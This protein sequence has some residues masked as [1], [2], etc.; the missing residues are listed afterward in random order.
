MIRPGQSRLQHS[1]IHG[2]VDAAQFHPCPPHEEA[3]ARLHYVAEQH[4]RLGVLL[5]NSGSGKSMLLAKLV[6]DLA[7]AGRHIVSVS[8]L[9]RDSQELLFEIAEKL[10]C[11]PAA[12]ANTMTLWRAITDRLKTHKYQQ[13]DT[14]FLFDDAHEASAETLSTICRLA[15]TDATEEARLTI[16]MAAQSDSTARLPRRLLD[17][18]ALRIDVEPWEQEDTLEFLAHV[19]EQLRRLDGATSDDELLPSEVFTG[20]AVQTLHQLSGGLPRR[21]TQLAQWALLAGAGLGL[22]QVNDE[23]VTSAAEELGVQS[24]V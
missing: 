18:T 9:G 13:E 14:V 10:G 21:V 19:V 23:V 16:I 22:E 20:K 15:D 24:L 6:S 2:H 11:N 5:G 4:L 8:L 12:T 17:R 1:P 3:L 7:G